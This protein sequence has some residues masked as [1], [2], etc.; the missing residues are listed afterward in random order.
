MTNT[1]SAIINFPRLH[2]ELT[3]EPKPENLVFLAPALFQEDSPPEYAHLIKNIRATLPLP[4]QEAQRSARQLQ[5][6]GAD[7]WDS[8]QLEAIAAIGQSKASKEREESA[9]LQDIKKFIASQGL[10]RGTNNPS[11][12]ETT[13][14]NVCIGKELM[15]CIAYELELAILETQAAIEKL[16]TADAAFKASLHDSS[17]HDEELQNI[18]ATVP[19]L[20][21]VTA[22]PEISLPYLTVLEAILPFI[23]DGAQLFT[24]DKNVLESFQDSGFLP[25]S[26]LPHL[27]GQ[28]QF[29]LLRMPAWRVLGRKGADPALPWTAKD[30]TLCFPAPAT[31]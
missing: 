26:P 2:E 22:A 29:S 14:T 17:L 12:T 7:L 30:M 5:D 11:S 23:P 20:A 19:S 24:N 18:F 8:R 15:L 21:T 27:P 25:E 16:A 10:A 31:S 9:E 3:P 1:T 13:V 4:L 6:F 28:T